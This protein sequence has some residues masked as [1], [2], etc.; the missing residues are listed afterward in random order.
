MHSARTD[1][2]VAMEQL[3]K[4]VTQVATARD[5]YLE[6]L[7]SHISE[8]QQASELIST[9]ADVKAA[10]AEKKQENLKNREAANQAQ[11]TQMAKKHAADM[12]EAHSIRTAAIA[13]RKEAAKIRAQAV[14]DAL[15]ASKA[16]QQVLSEAS[17]LKQD[18]ISQSELVNKAAAHKHTQI[19]QQEQALKSTIEHQQELMAQSS[20]QV[21]LRLHQKAKEFMQKEDE[22]TKKQAAEEA[23]AA[24]EAMAAAR[25]SAATF[26]MRVLMKARSASSAL[27][28]KAEAQA[29]V[30][31]SL[32]HIQHLQSEIQRT[33][34]KMETQLA[35]ATSAHTANQIKEKFEHVRS[36]LEAELTI[37]QSEAKEAADAMKQANLRAESAL[38][39][40]GICSYSPVK[41]QTSST[42]SKATCMSN[43]RDTKMGCDEASCKFICS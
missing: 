27:V 10:Q 7:N 23:K 34:N 6:Q 3:A 28:Q 5:A 37:T 32:A 39:E 30:K 17:K 42:K 12:A 31:Q 11:Y 2:K 21:D 14:K 4:G 25:S 9:E 26:K 41:A 13:D 36:K 29:S 19:E 18:A 20:D 33:D 38:I 24:E 35:S 8:T 1:W 43:C 22:E 16:K 40:A 15:L